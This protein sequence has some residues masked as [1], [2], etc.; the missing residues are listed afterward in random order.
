MNLVKWLR[1]N[2]KKVMAVV[3]IVIMFGFIGGTYLQQ[4]GQK[5]TRDRTIAYC[6]DKRKIT[7]NDLIIARQELEILK[8]LRADVLLKNL[9]LPQSRMLDLRMLLLGE[10]LFPAQKTSPVLLNEIKRLARL[11]SYHISNQQIHDIYQGPVTSDVYWLLLK[12]ETEIAGI[13]VSD[14]FAGSELAYLA[15][16]LFEGAQYKNVMSYLTS[17]LRIS[18]EEALTTYA[19]LMAVRHY[20]SMVCSSEDVTNSQVMYDVSRREERIDVEF[21]KFDSSVFAESQDPPSTEKTIEHFGKYKTSFAGD[22]NEANPYGFGYKLPARIRLEYI[23]VKLD[24]L[25][26]T[27][28]EPTQ[29]EMEQYWG[30]HKQEFTEL[31]PSDPND[32]NSTPTERIKDYPEVEHIIAKLLLQEKT[33]AKANMILQEAKTLTEAALEDKEPQDLTSDLFRQLAGDYKAAADQ[34]SEEH[35][36]KVYTALTGLLSATDIREDDY[37]GR[38]YI[39]G[40][41]HNPP[42]ILNMISLPRIVFSM[43]EVATAELGPFDPQKPRM[44]ENIGP[45]KDPIGEIMVVVRVTDAKEASVPESIDHGHSI[46]ALQLDQDPNKTTDDLYSAKEK[47]AEDLKKLAAMTTAKSKAKDFVKQIAMDGWDDAIDRFNQLYGQEKDDPNDPNT[48]TLQ[49]RMGLR[50][51]TKQTMQAWAVQNVGNPDG[52]RLVN[53]LKIEADLM[54][55]LYYLI[56]SNQDANSLETVPYL[57]EF[58]PDMSYYCLKDLTVRRLNRDDYKKIKP[59]Q[60]YRQELT[61]SQT[62]AAVHFNPENI[63]K[64]MNFIPVKEEEPEDANTPAEPKGKS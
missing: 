41:G 49:E 4:L 17:T 39:E 48:F 22:V 44:Y 33:D 21:V 3:V 47:V 8:A 46:I 59:L 58:K 61:H 52:R 9:P 45:L 14:K 63:L 25:S 54:D 26:A 32:P 18:E 5:R 13:T 16:R 19:K 36:A 60:L 15:P 55:R 31:V 51:I 1:K 42:Q 56:P 53:R 7:S 57:M 10:I 6:L 12:K 29:E 35:N 50:R 62:L 64:R 34:L 37:L 30:K 20:A 2:N 27:V 11:N 28:P 40:Y 24:D 43:D 23:A 38:L